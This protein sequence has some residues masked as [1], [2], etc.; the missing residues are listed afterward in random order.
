MQ[1][2]DRSLKIPNYFSSKLELIRSIDVI[3]DFRYL[4]QVNGVKVY[5]RGDELRGTF[6][7]NTDVA[8]AISVLIDTESY[9]NWLLG[10]PCH[11]ITRFDTVTDLVDFSFQA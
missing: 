3:R 6:R 8:F 7:I 4:H 9:H 1:P 10:Y 2:K 11:D 5:E